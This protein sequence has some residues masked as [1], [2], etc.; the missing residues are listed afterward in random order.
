MKSEMSAL[1]IEIS[2]LRTENA[3]LKSRIDSKSPQNKLPM[4]THTVKDNV[5]RPIKQSY[6]PSIGISDSKK[7]NSAHTSVDLNISKDMADGDTLE[8]TTVSYKKNIRKKLF[9]AM[10]LVHLFKR[11]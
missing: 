8:F 6:I 5:T 3:E 4:T 2:S 11:Q 9:S 1:R 10:V 7:S